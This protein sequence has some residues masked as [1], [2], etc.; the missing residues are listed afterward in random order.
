M[1]DANDSSARL[2]Q[3]HRGESRLAD[4]DDWPLI[5]HGHQLLREELVGASALYDGRRARSSGTASRI[6]PWRWSLVLFESQFPR[7]VRAQRR[8]WQALA[9]GDAGVR[10]RGAASSRGRATGGALRSMTQARGGPLT[11][12]LLS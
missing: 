6:V 5:R 4:G 12:F 10:C 7:H 2:Q 9:D 11:G 8:A 1:R 3:A